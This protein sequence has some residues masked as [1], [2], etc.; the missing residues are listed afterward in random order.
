MGRRLIPARVARHVRISPLAGNDDSVADIRIGR[1][2][3]RLLDLTER[4]SS[5]GI[6]GLDLTDQKTGAA[7]ILCHLRLQRL[8]VRET[9]VTS[10]EIEELDLDLPA[11]EVALEV[12]QE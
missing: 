4:K 3:R 6:A 10:D 9:P 1:H 11:V 8:D 5:Q 12:E 7:A 2:P